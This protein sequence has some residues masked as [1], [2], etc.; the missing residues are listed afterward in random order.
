MT[1]HLADRPTAPGFARSGETWRV[2]AEPGGWVGTR[3]GV[4]SAKKCCRTAVVL[5]PDR[6]ARGHD[7]LLCA[8]HVQEYGMWIENRQLVSWAMRP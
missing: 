8:V 4:C 3:D 5:R 6:M 2:E 7:F 1:G